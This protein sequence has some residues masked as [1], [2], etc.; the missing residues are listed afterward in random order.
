MSH[1]QI[2]SQSLNPTKNKDSTSLLIPRGNMKTKK[3][4]IF[5]GRPLNAVVVSSQHVRFLRY[6]DEMSITMHLLTILLT[7][8]YG[9]LVC[10]VFANLICF[11]FYSCVYVC[12]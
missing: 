9:M 7:V 12:V 4:G 10:Y 6:V 11:N 8:G 3:N 5:I 1:N 2:Y